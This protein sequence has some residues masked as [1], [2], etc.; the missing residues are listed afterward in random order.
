MK[1][2]ILT[3]LCIALCGIAM[4][5]FIEIIKA[6]SEVKSVNKYIKSDTTI[7]VKNKIAEKNLLR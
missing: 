4:L 6:K 7:K 5:S 2:N 3:C 1:K